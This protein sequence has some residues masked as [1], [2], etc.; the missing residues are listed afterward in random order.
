MSGARH[1]L[2]RGSVSADDLEADIKADIAAA[3]GAQRDLKAA[4]QNGAAARMGEAVDEHLDE[5]NAAKDG[6]WRPNHA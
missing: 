3:R 4:H 6:T 1:F 5:L 2:P